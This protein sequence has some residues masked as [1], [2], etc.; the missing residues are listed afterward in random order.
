MT[1][2]IDPLDADI[3]QSEAMH[4]GP[5]PSDPNNDE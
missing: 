3:D 2:A 4:N 5:A 1:N